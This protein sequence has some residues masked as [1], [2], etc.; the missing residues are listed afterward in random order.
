[1]QAAAPAFIA[2]ALWLWIVLGV[3]GLAYMALC[4]RQYHTSYS[5]FIAGLLAGI[6]V[7]ACFVRTPKA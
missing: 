4:P 1:M 7:V 5:D 3:V 2:R 6:A